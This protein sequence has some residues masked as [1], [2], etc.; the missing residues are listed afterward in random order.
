[1][2][3]R[4]YIEEEAS[5]VKEVIDT[6]FKEHPELNDEPEK[7]WTEVYGKYD[8]VRDAEQKIVDKFEDKCLTNVHLDFMLITGFTYDFWC[9]I[10]SAITPYNYSLL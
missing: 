4:N 6:L 2:K 5:F 1:M 8:F 7:V 10:E 9:Y 3:N